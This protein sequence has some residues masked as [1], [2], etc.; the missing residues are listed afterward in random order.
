MSESTRRLDA[1]RRFCLKMRGRRD[2]WLRPSTEKRLCAEGINE[3]VFR[4]HYQSQRTLAKA[5]G[6]PFH[7]SYEDWVVWWLD[8]GC[9]KHRGSGASKYCMARIGD[10]GPY[11]LGNVRCLTNSQNSKDLQRSAESNAKRSATLKKYTKTQQH[12]ARLSAAAKGKQPF[13]GFKQS[14][15]HIMKRIEAIRKTKALKALKARMG[16]EVLP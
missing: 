14:K 7:F 3:F 15:E 12:R 10:V 8:S 11:E 1:T 9:I 6:I 4:N 5:R 16:A 13:L 2:L